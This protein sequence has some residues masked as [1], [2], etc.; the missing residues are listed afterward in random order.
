[1]KQIREESRRKLA[2]ATKAQLLSRF[3]AEEQ[4]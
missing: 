2:A 3:G 4:R 1:M